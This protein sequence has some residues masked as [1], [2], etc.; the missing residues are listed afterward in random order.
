MNRL[1]LKNARGEYYYGIPIEDLGLA[2]VLAIEF[3]NY[4]PFIMITDSDDNSIFESENGVIIFPD[5]IDLKKIRSLGL[6][7]SLM[8]QDISEMKSLLKRRAETK[9]YS[10]EFIEIEA[11][12]IAGSISEDIDIFGIGWERA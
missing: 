11:A 2:A 10:R 4:V 7:E 6:V 1:Y 3:K 5:N 8:P 12:L 9:P